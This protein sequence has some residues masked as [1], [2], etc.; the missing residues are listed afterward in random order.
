[1]IKMSKQSENGSTLANSQD[2]MEK[3]LKALRFLLSTCNL[4]LREFIVAFQLMKIKRRNTYRNQKKLIKVIGL[5]RLST[6]VTQLYPMQTTR[7]TCGDNTLMRIL[8][9]HTTTTD[10]HSLDSTKLFTDNLTKNSFNNS[11]QGFLRYLRRKVD[12]LLSR[13]T[14]IYSQITQLMMRIFRGIMIY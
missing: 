3:L 6:T 11:S 12:L 1:M 10:S 13:I 2:S 7:E 9:G 14:T 8:N 5:S 4:L